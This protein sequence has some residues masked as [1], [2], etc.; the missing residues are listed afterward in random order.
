MLAKLWKKVLLAVC[1]IACIYNVMAKLVNRTS[2][3]DNLNSAND[4]NTVFEIFQKES[5]VDSNVI[6]NTK[7]VTN[8]SNNITEKPKATEVVLDEENIENEVQEQENTNIQEE[9]NI[10]EQPENEEKNLIT[11]LTIY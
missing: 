2:L 7:N 4:G 6:N 8:T 9:E 1:I 3:E 10:E 11:I 5:T